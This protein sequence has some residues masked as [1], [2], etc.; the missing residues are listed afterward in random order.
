MGEEA[1]QKEI[2]DKKKEEERKRWLTEKGGEPKTPKTAKSAKGKKVMIE[3]N[4]SE[5]GGKKDTGKGDKKDAGKGPKE[6][7]SATAWDKK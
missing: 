4:K 6:P 5:K 7:K 2:E 3:E 1:Y